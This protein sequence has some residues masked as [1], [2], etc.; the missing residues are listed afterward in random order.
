[1]SKND[2]SNNDTITRSRVNQPF[3]LTSGTVGGTGDAAGTV[4]IFISPG[5]L[6]FPTRA[7]PVNSI[8][9]QSISFPGQANYDY[10]VF[11]RSDSTF[12]VS[13]SNAGIAT[14]RDGVAPPRHDAEFLGI[15][16]IGSPVSQANLTGPWNTGS[17]AGVPHEQRSQAAAAIASRPRAVYKQSTP[18]SMQVTGAGGSFPSTINSLSTASGFAWL[19]M[20]DGGMNDAGTILHATVRFVS[21]G[22]LSGSD[23]YITPIFSVWS[24]DDTMG[25]P[26]GVWPQ[27]LR[28]AAAQ[29]PDNGARGQR[30]I[31]TM[32]FT[33][34]NNGTTPR[35][36]SG[37]GLGVSFD[38]STNRTDASTSIRITGF[39][40]IARPNNKLSDTTEPS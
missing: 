40:F 6:R 16:R 23:L 2:W 38:P 25:T 7:N 13:G 18:G 14:F 4:R 21:S 30:C 39:S 27:T 10:A 24:S 19:N 32:S 36:G 12:L 17:T 34:V 22:A 28:Y 3:F 35:A 1:M 31:E 5:I 20:A 26:V 11:A 8:N 29:D 15:V 9:L 33:V 37:Y